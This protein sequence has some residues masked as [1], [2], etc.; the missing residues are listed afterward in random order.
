ML[1]SITL[2]GANKFRI[3]TLVDATV[4]FAGQIARAFVYAGELTPEQVA[5]IYQ[6]SGQALGISPKA[7]GDHIERLDSTNI[8]FVGDG[9]EPQ[10]AITLEVAA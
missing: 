1:N 4:E 5:K 8:Y 9:I 10:D 7:D 3:G 6:K 2:G